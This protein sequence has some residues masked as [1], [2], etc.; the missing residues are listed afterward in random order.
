MILILHLQFTAMPN[1]PAMQV[2]IYLAN[3]HLTLYQI[4]K[5][6]SMFFFAQWHKCFVD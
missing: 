6:V 5:Y 3:S 1:M 2:L 4:L